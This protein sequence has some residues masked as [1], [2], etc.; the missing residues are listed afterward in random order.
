MS[1]RI[2]S[3]TYQIDP[4]HS[5]VEFAVKHL[6][7]ST[8][9]GRFADVKGTLDLPESGD[10]KVDITI[11]AASIN[12]GVEPRDVHLRSADFFDVEKYPELR[13][14]STTATRHGDGWRLEGNLTMHGVTLP[15]TLAV[16]EE[17]AGIDPW[18]NQKV[19]FSATGKVN[20]THFGLTWN[21][22]LEAGGVLVGEDVKISI[23]A[24]LVKAAA[25][26]A[27]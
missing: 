15:V 16:T 2:Q 17:G 4:T 19:A 26:A 5:A 21:A 1:T 22:A 3:G 24:Q 18:G 7:I 14:V 20:R 6:M 9:K 23:D 8:V 10:A 13:F 12:T 11:G 25:K 27:A